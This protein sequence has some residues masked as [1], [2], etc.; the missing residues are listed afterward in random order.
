MGTLLNR[1]RY[2][3]GS[4]TDEIIM[5]ST[6]NPEVLAVCYAQGWASHADYMTKKEAEAVTSIGTAFRNN[7]SI[8]HFDELQYFGI[9]SLPNYCFYFCYYLASLKIPSTVTYIGEHALQRVYGI[10]N[11]IFPQALTSIGAAGCFYMT[12]LLSLDLSNTVVTV[13]D[14]QA[15]DG[16]SSL[17]YIKLPSTISTI[18]NY[19]FRGCSSLNSLTIT[20]VTPPSLGTDALR[21]TPSTCPIYVPAE[22]VE[23]YKTASGWSSFASRIQAIPT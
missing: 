22:S 6:S 13:I 5:T 9:T 18:G 15:F 19:A 8:T 12:G 14:G 3:G 1:R 23:A 17:T 11:I 10:T 4:S 2:M 20:A 21:N 7:Q 16:C